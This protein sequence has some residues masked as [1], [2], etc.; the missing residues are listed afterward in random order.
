MP[1]ITVNVT[2]LPAQHDGVTA[3]FVIML[4][5]W[6]KYWDATCDSGYTVS[7]ITQMSTV[8]VYSVK[9]IS[10]VGQLLQ[11]NAPSVLGEQKAFSYS[12]F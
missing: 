3:N 12:F 7:T 10:I 11:K 5:T 2:F 6:E 4:N 8:H 9:K 1:V